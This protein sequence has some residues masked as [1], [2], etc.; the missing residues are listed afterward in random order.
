MSQTSTKSSLRIWIGGGLLA[1]AA[2]IS[3][4]LLMARQNKTYADE[5]K[6]RLAGVKA[7]PIVK[8]V[9]VGDAASGQDLSLIGE[10]RPF[11]SVTLYAKTSGYMDKIFVDK[12]DKV[13]QGQLMATIVSPE[14]DQAYLAA[15]ADLENKKKI[16]ARD[17]QLL[18]KEYIAPQDKEQV[19]TDVRVATAQ[20]ESLKQQQDYKNITAPFSGTVTARYADPGALVQ[21]ATNSQTSAQPVV[22]VSELG[23]IRVYVYVEQAVATYLKEGYPVRITLTE[24]PD[25][26]IKASIT[27]ISGELDPKTRMELVEVDL[28]NQDDIIIP[29]SYVNV[30]LKMPT[31]SNGHPQ[32]P[33]EALVIKD[34]MTTVPVIQPDSTLVYKPV[35]VGDNDGVHATI[36]DGIQNG[37]VIGVNVGAGYNNGQKVRIAQ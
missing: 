32:V 12:G 20:V 29:G 22:T 31:A 26:N 2:V 15:V 37:D 4:L 5:T 33:S 9:K 21:N 17:E 25:V 34:K 30:L 24:R 3:I 8:A 27:R 16:L 1:A 6:S 35:K 19:E 10:A 11:Q 28:S 36:L 23:R 14:T 18:Q 13:R 7:G